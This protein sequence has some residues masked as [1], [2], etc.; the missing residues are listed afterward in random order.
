MAAGYIPLED[1]ASV[2]ARRRRR[3]GAL[4]VGTLAATA[5][6]AAR[7][8]GGLLELSAASSSEATLG[9]SCSNEYSSEASP[10]PGVGYLHLDPRYV[11]E[12]ARL[13]TLEADKLQRTI[14][15]HR[16]S[17]QY[18]RRELEHRQAQVARARAATRKH[19]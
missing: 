17:E 19:E 18:A 9:F 15:T 12:P 4:A 13:T 7:R 3:W 11:V 5:G 16:A 6:V 14:D 10:G 2:A 1:A 8:S